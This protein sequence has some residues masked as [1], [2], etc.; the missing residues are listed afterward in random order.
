[1]LAGDARDGELAPNSP[2]TCSPRP[3]PTT[4]PLS[5]SATKPLPPLWCRPLEY[6]RHPREA[7]LD[8]WDRSSGLPIFPV[9]PPLRR[10]PVAS[11]R[12]RRKG[13]RRRRHDSRLPSVDEP[14]I[15]RVGG[16]HVRIMDP[17][18]S[19]GGRDAGGA[20]AAFPLGGAGSRP[21]HQRG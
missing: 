2:T 3:S 13:R 14:T 18:D 4:P 19:Q 21:G 8:A 6:S 7:L 17:I 5:S 15:V 11:C 9:G 20:R 12:Q 16:V 1:M 10:R